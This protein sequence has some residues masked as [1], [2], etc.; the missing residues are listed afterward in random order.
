MA[1]KMSFK[2]PSMARNKRDVDAE[3][4]REQIEEAA[5]ALFL[6]DGYEATSM[7]AVAK[8]AGVAPNTLYW[9]FASKDDLLVAT[10]DRLVNQALLQLAGMQDLALGDQLRWLLGEFQQASKLISTVHSRLDR[11]ETVREWHDRFH[12]M[13]D[14]MLVQQ[15][16]SKG[17]SRTKASV[18]ATVGTY[19]VEGLLSH[20]HTSQQ[21]DKVVQWLAG[22]GKL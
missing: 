5:C 9:Y 17:M 14:A 8:A 1:F 2:M 16:V 3:V 21:F 15:M 4:K 10:L 12:E 22:N 7:A 20:P 13:L 19:V 18:M 6:A 11:S